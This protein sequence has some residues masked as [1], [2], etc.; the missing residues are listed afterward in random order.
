MDITAGLAWIVGFI[1]YRL[2][3]KT[4]MVFGYTI[5][6]MAIT[7]V[8]TIVFR[9]LSELSKSHSLRGVQNVN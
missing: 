2:L 4:D 6:D 9:K 5:P 3:M 8:V 1:V 7:V